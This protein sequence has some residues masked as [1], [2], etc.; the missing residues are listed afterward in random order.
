MN[1]YIKLYRSCLEHE[2]LANDNT[3]FIVFTKLLLRVDRKSGTL[4]TGRFKLGHLCNLKPITAWKAL[5]RLKNAKMVTLESNNKYTKIT[6]CNWYKWQSLDNTYGNN[7]VTTKYQPGITIQERRIKNKEIIPNGIVETLRVYDHFIE[8]FNKNP[9]TY[10]LTDKR[11]LK[12]R[13]RLKDAGIDMLIKAI[14]TVADSAWHMGDN[15]RGWTAD[16]D[17]IIRSYEQV[18]RFAAQPQS[19]VKDIKEYI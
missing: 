8:R 14:D 5:Q 2:L 3:A 17:Y 15:D 7:Q 4:I 18:E 9:N 19:K 10:K 1:G 16:L 13:S 12:I 11:K 6:I